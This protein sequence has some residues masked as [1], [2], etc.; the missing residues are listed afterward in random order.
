VGLGRGDFIDV[1]L[2]SF[3]CECFVGER[4]FT[5]M[6]LKAADIDNEDMA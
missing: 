4:T 2:L 6:S 1:C 3:V 5:K